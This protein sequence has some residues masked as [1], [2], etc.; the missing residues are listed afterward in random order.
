MADAETA[1]HAKA[2]PAV[3]IEPS[4]SAAMAD[5]MAD[6][7]MAATATEHGLALPRPRLVQLDENMKMELLVSYK[8]DMWWPMPHHLSDPIL[9]EWR[10]GAEEKKSSGTG[11]RLVKE[12]INQ[13]DR[14]LA[15][16]DTSLISTQCSS[17]T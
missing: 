10:N 14:P 3:A 6:V 7:E 2:Q 15:S 17:T 16:I 1:E 9:E 4:H 11:E 13:T 5:A 8:N 12:H